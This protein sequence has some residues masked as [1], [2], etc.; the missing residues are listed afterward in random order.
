MRTKF[1][2]RFIP[3]LRERVLVDAISHQQ[4]MA[5]IFTIFNRSAKIDSLDPTTII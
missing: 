5:P 3:I 2:R 1:D 4:W